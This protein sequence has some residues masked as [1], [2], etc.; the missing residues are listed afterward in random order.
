M[1]SPK[2]ELIYKSDAD[3][4]EATGK[5][6]TGLGEPRALARGKAPGPPLS[7]SS[8]LFLAQLG[9][10]ASFFIALKTRLS[11]TQARTRC[12][13]FLILRLGGRSW[14]FRLLICWPRVHLFHSS[15]PPSPSTAS[16]LT[17][18]APPPL[19]VTRGCVGGRRRERKQGCSL[20]PLGRRGGLLQRPE[21]LHPA[22][23]TTHQPKS[24]LYN[25]H[26]P[27]LPTPHKAGPPFL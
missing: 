9:L 3:R 20:W 1:P 12:Q 5:T 18:K 6:A 7:S 8:L 16:P 25:L 4:E 23:R 14:L 17:S 22:K 2:A 10:G 26:P 13:K 27:N 21:F 15:L 11:K 24:S 19:E